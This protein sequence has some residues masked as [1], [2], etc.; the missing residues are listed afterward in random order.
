M[1]MVSTVPTTALEDCS[2]ARMS[3]L[4]HG[5]AYGLLLLSPKS[6]LRRRERL[7]GCPVGRC[8]LRI[9]RGA[10]GGTAQSVTDE[11]CSKSWNSY[12]AGMG[13]AIVAESLRYTRPDTVRFL[14]VT[15]CNVRAMLS[16]GY[17]SDDQS[18][19]V[20][21]FLKLATVP[22]AVGTK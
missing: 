1:F 13:V 18:R 7:I 16:L 14:R 8:D 11:C 15:D 6:L 12:P 9:G 2:D 21:N 17:R 19:T 4:L 20:R 22:A 10:S 5:V 3:P